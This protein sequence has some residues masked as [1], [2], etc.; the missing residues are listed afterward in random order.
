LAALP[1]LGPV[2]LRRLDAALNGTVES[3]LEMPPQRLQALCNTTASSSI[4][5]WREHEDPS[6]TDR[7]LAA[8]GADYQTFEDP[9]YPAPLLHYPDAP[10]GLYRY[11]A[12]AI[13]QQPAIAVVGTRKP[14]SYGRKITRAWVRTLVEHGFTI[15]SGMAEGI[16]TEAHLSALDAGGRTAAFLGGGLK[17]CYPASN[18]G[19]MERIAR[20]AG[21]WS[22]FPLWRS[23]DRRSFPQRNRLV[24]GVSDAVLVI[25]SGAIGG[26]LIT[27]RMAAEMGRSVYAM[28]G[29]VDCPESAGCHALIRD[30]AQLVTCAEDVLQDLN[31]MPASLRDARRTASTNPST[32]QTSPPPT[33]PQLTA[34]LEVIPKGESLHPDAISKALGWPIHQLHPRLLELELSGHLQRRL[35]GHYER[36]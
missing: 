2:Q 18:R 13:I 6:R 17:R 8:M 5:A 21:V 35:D 1:G 36:A 3:L 25:E 30:G 14:S 32:I 31:A 28:P 15:V 24:A 7:A 16:D 26:S 9:D 27:A 33:D 19:L 10:V 22:E 12:N 29:R 34:L 20:S 23:A 4:R 11:T